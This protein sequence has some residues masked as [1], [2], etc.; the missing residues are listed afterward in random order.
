[1]DTTAVIIGAGHAGLAMSRRL[2]ERSIDHVVLERGEVANSWQTQRWDSLR[3]LTPNWLNRLPG[4]RYSGEDPDGFSSM[5]EVVA[6]LRAYADRIDA[7]VQSGVTVTQVARTGTGYEVHTD[8]GVWRCETVVLASGAANLANVPAFAAG[9]PASVVQL[10]PLTY[11]SP[12]GLDER[13]VLIV[14]GSATGVQLADEIQRSGR[15][16]T[17]AVGEHVRMPREYRG[18]DI[19]WWL[20][21]A[22]VLDERHDE[23]D[24]LVRARHVPSP[25]LIGSPEHRSIDLT[26][27]RQSGVEITGRV[28]A[29]RDGVALC[30]GG[31]ANVCRL[32]DLKLN[33]LLHRFDSWAHRNG[34]GVVDAPEQFAPT[35]L[36]APSTLEIDLRRRDIG[37]VIWATGFRPDYSWL[38]V[39]VLDRRR[40]IR[41]DG[42]V[43]TQAPGL[44]V[45]GGNLLRTRRSSYLAGAEADTAAIADQLHD[46]LPT[47]THH[48]QK[49]TQP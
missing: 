21:W 45:L 23:V 20:E 29:V 31:L 6:Y 30:S 2:T 34:I 40:R 7:P 14:G 17:L 27:L 39:P 32:A 37:T 44:Y 38:D 9:F 24:D 41:H 35:I 8:W 13:P 25:Q 43:V 46:H 28:G 16:V 11:R 22:G 19:F 49:V 36:K 18:R 10:T 3:L 1:M 42:G 15:R 47:S 12:A 48:H 5:P 26:T 33:R 4:Q